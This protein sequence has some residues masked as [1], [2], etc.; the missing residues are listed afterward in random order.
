L[1]KYHS[2]AL[3]A[4]GA[5]RC[6]GENYYGEL[7]NGTFTDAHTP[8]NVIGITNA[9]A[10][11][12]GGSSSC[13]L[14]ATGAIRCWGLGWGRIPVTAPEISNAIAITMG[15]NRIF[16]TPRGG[17]IKSVSASGPTRVRGAV[18]A[19]LKVAAGATHACALLADGALRCWGAN[20][21][22]QPG[23]RRTTGSNWPVNVIG[24]P[25]V[26][27]QSSHSSK[28]TITDVGVATGRA[29]GKLYDLRD[30]RRVHQRQRPADGELDV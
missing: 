25:G 1:G 16:A 10:V 24:T 20:N 13:A 21:V 30:H 4:S 2:C 11:A 12:A 5:V 8:V 27:W 18:A 14:L 9:T 15:S 28:A 29:V 23:N 26:V 17:L 6:W 7:G 19:P 22:G 3:L